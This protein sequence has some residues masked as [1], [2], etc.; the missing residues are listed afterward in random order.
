M[1]DIPTTSATSA[2]S[3]RRPAP[4]PGPPA[5]RRRST[6]IPSARTMPPRSTRGATALASRAPQRARRV[7]PQ[8]APARRTRTP[9]T[10]SRRAAGREQLTEPAIPRASGPRSRAFRAARSSRRAP[11]MWWRWS[12]RRRTRRATHWRRRFFRARVTMTWIT[13]T[14]PG[15]S[16]TRHCTNF[17]QRTAVRATRHRGAS[18][19]CPQNWHAICE[20]LREKGSGTMTIRTCPL[21]IACALRAPRFVRSR[22]RGLRGNPGSG[23]CSA[24]ADGESLGSNAS[25]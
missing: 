6:R 22:T 23:R 4:P 13:C 5:G 19:G 11:D 14:V 20:L 7:A 8:A 10:R 24:A 17:V 21:R 15:T 25:A 3:C 16:S 12:F 18:D 9:A 2:N 1:I